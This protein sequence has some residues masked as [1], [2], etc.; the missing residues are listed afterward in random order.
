MI[1]LLFEF[2][3][4][5]SDVLQFLNIWLQTCW[6]AGTLK[7]TL[8]SWWNYWLRSIQYDSNVRHLCPNWGH[9]LGGQSINSQPAAPFYPRAPWLIYLAPGGSQI[10]DGML[11]FTKNVNILSYTLKPELKDARLHCLWCCLLLCCCAYNLLNLTWIYRS[12]KEL[13]LMPLER[14]IVYLLYYRL[15]YTVCE[16]KFTLQK[17]WAERTSW[18]WHFHSFDC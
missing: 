6:T 17:P 8:A 5:K 10:Q 1:L 18:G 3:F 15:R 13:Y 9:L 16:M 14:A 11:I 2:F 12:V 7:L 4:F